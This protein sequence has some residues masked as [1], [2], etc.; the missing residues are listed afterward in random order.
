MIKL[1]ERHKNRKEVGDI[2]L[3]VSGIDIERDEIGSLHHK[4]LFEVVEVNN[5]KIVVSP[6]GKR[7]ITSIILNS[8]TLKLNDLTMQELLLLKE[9]IGIDSEY[10]DIL[11]LYIKSRL[12]V[13][14][15]EVINETH[16]E[17]ENIITGIL[18]KV[19]KENSTAAKQG[20]LFVTGKT[21][22]NVVKDMIRSKIPMVYRGFLD[23]PLSDIAVANIANFAVDNF[24]PS[25]DKA[26]LASKAMMVAAMTSAI[27]SLNIEA[28]IK[29]VLGTVDLSD[30]VEATD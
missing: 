17:K 20:A 23:S 14:R 19:V 5:E 29:D 10:I 9:Y 24:A 18:D 6:N 2:V 28:I 12:E 25:N 15:L 27:E 7:N 16:N 22:N 13:I 11:N 1:N 3:F 26:R 30:I 8:S 4:H 21:L